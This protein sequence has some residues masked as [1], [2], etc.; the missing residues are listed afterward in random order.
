MVTPPIPPPVLSS[1][2]LFRAT[3]YDPIWGEGVQVGVICRTHLASAPALAGRFLTTSATWE[4]PYYSRTPAPDYS[5]PFLTSH[6]DGTNKP[7]K[8]WDL[9]SLPA[10]SHH[11]DL[12]ICEIP[13]SIKT[14]I[15]QHTT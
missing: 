10:I 15:T 6:A 7:V 11:V 13:A 3:L 8:E 9:L 5:L 2:F 12:F 1:S 4:A 14:R